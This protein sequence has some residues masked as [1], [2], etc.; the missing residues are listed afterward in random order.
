M[1]R[2]QIR[3]TLAILVATRLVLGSSVM[4]SWVSSTSTNRVASIPA[5]MRL[6][7]SRRQNEIVPFVAIAAELHGRASFMVSS[8]NR[9]PFVGEASNLLIERYSV[10]S[11]S[12][13][14]RE[15]TPIAAA[16]RPL[17]C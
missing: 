12:R 3:L 5:K 9:I 15:Q 11:M 16:L 1:P 10:R 14:L 6:P 8:R 4:A 13:P 2:S 17:R 7:R